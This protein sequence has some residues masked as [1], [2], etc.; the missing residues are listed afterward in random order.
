MEDQEE[1]DLDTSVTMS[2]LLSIML[3]MCSRTSLEERTPSET[4]WI[5]TT[6]CSLMALEVLANSSK[7]IPVEAGDNS[8][9]SKTHLL[10]LALGEWEGACKALAVWEAL[11]VW[12]VLEASRMICSVAWEEWEVEVS[13]PSPPAQWEWAPQPPSKH[14]HSLM[15][16]AKR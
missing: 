16:V 14:R 2:S 9:N 1:L 11:E 6:S 8:N 5:M 3:R 12:E 4:S 15:A 13:N 10:A 7:A